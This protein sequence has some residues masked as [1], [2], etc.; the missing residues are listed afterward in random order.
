MYNDSFQ[1][2]IIFRDLKSRLFIANIIP[3]LQSYQIVRDNVVYSLDEVPEKS[4][5]KLM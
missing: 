4:L 2:I 3:L 1:K 5:F